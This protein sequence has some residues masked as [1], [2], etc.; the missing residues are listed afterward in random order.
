MHDVTAVKLLI[1]LPIIGESIFRQSVILLLESNENGSLGVILNKPMED[2]MIRELDFNLP[3]DMEVG[4][5]VGGPV[6]PNTIITLGKLRSAS[7]RNTMTGNVVFV[8]LYQ[9]HEV[10]RNSIDQM[11][12]FC[13][14]AGW[15]AGQ[16]EEELN[17]GCWHVTGLPFLE[18]IFCPDPKKLWAK[19]LK[20]CGGKL[21]MLANYPEELL[22][23]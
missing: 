11:R 10:L 17:L 19:M 14:Y 18:D 3:D 21:A 13:G 4:Y 12:I 8:D 5:M 2:K 15:S 23:N 16:L 22:L 9:D 6:S 1:S 7:G 20:A